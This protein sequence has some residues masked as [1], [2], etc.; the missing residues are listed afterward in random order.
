MQRAAVIGRI[1]KEFDVSDTKSNPIVPIPAVYAADILPVPDDTSELADDGEGQGTDPFDKYALYLSLSQDSAKLFKVR[2]R[3][4]AIELSVFDLNTDFRVAFLVLQAESLQVRVVIPL[5]DEKSRLW[6]DQCVMQS[7][8]RFFIAEQDSSSYRRFDS[9]L[10]LP[11]AE[12]VLHSVFQ[13]STATA[14]DVLL[15]ISS[16]LRSIAE[17]ESI[18]SY[19]A[20]ID[21][22]QVNVCVVRDF[23]NT[24]ECLEAL[25]E[26]KRPP[27]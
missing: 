1:E 9:V 12:R 14:F 2:E 13:Q 11:D 7:S 10:V 25:E 22:T 6:L 18:P 8:I 26:F 4:L 16:S 20:D 27:R 21:V 3:P 17:P 23:F 5:C 15:A 24:D 19:I